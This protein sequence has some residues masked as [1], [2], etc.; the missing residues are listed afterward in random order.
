MGDIHFHIARVLSVVFIIGIAGC[1][2]AIPIVAV[3]FA[4]VLFEKDPEEPGDRTSQES[5]AP[6]S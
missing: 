6:K 1:A 5:P 3:K 2:I 4:M